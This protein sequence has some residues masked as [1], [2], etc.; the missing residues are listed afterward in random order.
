MIWT[1]FKVYQRY[2]YEVVEGNKEG[3]SQ[4]YGET[5]QSR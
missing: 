5:R 2:V 4:A 3:S 1:I